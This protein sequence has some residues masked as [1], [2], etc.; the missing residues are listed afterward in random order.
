MIYVITGHLGSGKSLLAVQL[1][2]EYLRQGK[3]VASNITLFPEYALPSRSRASPIK[4]PYIPTAHH[5]EALGQ[6]YDGAYDEDRF[7]LVLLDEA[8]SWLNSRDWADKDRRGLFT[9]ITHARKFGYDVAL[10][11]QDYEALDAQIR[12]SVTEIYVKCARLDRIKFPFLPLK[13]PRMHVATARYQSATGPMVKRWF[14]R[15]NDL[16]KAYDTREA[17][18]PEVL[19]T[20][21]G[22]V[23]MRAITTLL[24]PWHLKGR[25]LP[26]RPPLWFYPVKLFAALLLALLRPVAELQSRRRVPSPA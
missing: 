15:G 12:R 14:S 20:E 8:G 5:L 23:D 4:L 19:Y 10:I 9:W 11:V 18:R 1:A 21:T 7:G 6:G 26:P 17:V 13:L 16:F 2:Y 22:P 25:Y 24:S 3:R